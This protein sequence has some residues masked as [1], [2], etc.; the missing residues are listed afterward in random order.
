MKRNIQKTE[1]CKNQGC[2]ALN[3]QN[4]IRSGTFSLHTG[5]LE[6]TTWCKWCKFIHKTD[7]PCDIFGLMVDMLKALKIYN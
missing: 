1:I 2:K 6:I 3:F 5:T 7:F 4:I